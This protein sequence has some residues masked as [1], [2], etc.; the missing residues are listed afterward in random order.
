MMWPQNTSGWRARFGSA[1]KKGRGGGGI[2]QCAFDFYMYHKAHSGKRS[3]CAV[4]VPP[5]RA[6][7][8]RRWHTEVQW[9][10]APIDQHAAYLH[11]THGT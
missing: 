2:A 3:L 1:P 7:T 10:T 5:A 4:G 11:K 6:V 9:P 8:A